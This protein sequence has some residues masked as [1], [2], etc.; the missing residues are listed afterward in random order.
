MKIFADHKNLTCKK[1]NNVRVLRWRLIL[2]EYNPVVEYIPG[3][4]NIV[5]DAL[6]QLPN[7]R[8]QKTTHESTY[9]TET[10]SE[11]YEKD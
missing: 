10:I 5:A 6:S 9:I 11:L 4:K 7:N 2:E 3:E 8:N 1:F